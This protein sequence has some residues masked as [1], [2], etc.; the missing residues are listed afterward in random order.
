MIYNA[1]FGFEDAVV[2]N[3]FIVVQANRI[4]CDR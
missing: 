3:L 4:E 2:R 1:F